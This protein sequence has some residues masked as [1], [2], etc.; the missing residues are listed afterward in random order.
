VPEA[1]SPVGTRL[2]HRLVGL[3]RSKLRGV[4]GR[5]SPLCSLTSLSRSVVHVSWR[6]RDLHGDASSS[7]V[8][9]R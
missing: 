9:Q 4:R 8:G 1:L 2:D 3:L 7:P 5:G 6:P